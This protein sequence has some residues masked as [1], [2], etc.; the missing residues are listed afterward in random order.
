[1]GDVT[2]RSRRLRRALRQGHVATYLTWGVV[3][4]L[5]KRGRAVRWDTTQNDTFVLV[6]LLECQ[7]YPVV[8]SNH[9]HI[10]LDDRPGLNAP[11]VLLT[12]CQKCPV[13]VKM[14]HRYFSHG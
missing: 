14:H 7:K 3:G 5:D 4:S 13:C 10:P 12:P 1:M 2:P 6:S 9:G 11:W 8:K